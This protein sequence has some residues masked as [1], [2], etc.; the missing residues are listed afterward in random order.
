MLLVNLT[1]NVECCIE[2]GRE[3]YNDLC[4]FSLN[5]LFIFGTEFQIWTCFKTTSYISAGPFTRVKEAVVWWSVLF[6]EWYLAHP[7]KTRQRV[8]SWKPCGMEV[9]CT[10]PWPAAQ[11]APMCLSQGETLI[12]IHTQ[13]VQPVLSPSWQQ[14]MFSSYW[15]LLRNCANTKPCVNFGCCCFIKSTPYTKS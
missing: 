3:Q 6:T 13:W 7:G 14:K 15:S 5:S 9:G 8:S 12:K 2:I 11:R 1:V 10:C 4:G